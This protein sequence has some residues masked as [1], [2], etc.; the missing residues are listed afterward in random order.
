MATYQELKGAKI[1]NYTEDPDNPYVGQLWY[2]TSTDSL[3]IRKETLGSAWSSGGDL[4]TRRGEGGS[5]VNGT[6]TAALAFGGET[7]P[8]LAITEAYNGSTWTEVNDLNA[9]NRVQGSAGTQTSALSFGGVPVPTHDETELWNGTNWTEVADLSQ[10]RSQMPQGSGTSTNG[11]GYGGQTPASPGFL[12][13]TEE[14]SGTTPST[15]T[16]TA[17]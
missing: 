12:T 3:R 15:V 5:S 8:D 7:P 1:K 9:T 6:Q 10:A 4:N 17:S 16:F 2:N 14:W 13:L 11:L